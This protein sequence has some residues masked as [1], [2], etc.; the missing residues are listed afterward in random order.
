M[1][2]KEFKEYVDKEL[3]KLGISEDVKIDYID[4][5]DPI[6]IEISWDSYGLS[7]Y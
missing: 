6:Q 7:I 2:W 4:I 3:E 5:I 1:T